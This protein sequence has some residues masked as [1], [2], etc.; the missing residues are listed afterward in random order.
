M[1]AAHGVGADLA[2]VLALLIVEGG[3]RAFLPHLL[4]AALQRAV[5][6]PQMN[7]VALAVAENLNLDVARLLKIFL[8]IHGVVAECGLGFRARGRQRVGKILARAGDLHAATA[9]ASGGFHEHGEADLVG[10]LQR[11]IVVR[12]AAV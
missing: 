3:R 4:M 6:F 7:G 2:D 12:H 5:A 11:F 1:Q 8:E 10:D 9:A